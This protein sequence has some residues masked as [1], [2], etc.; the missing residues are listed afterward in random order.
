MIRGKE[1]VLQLHKFNNSQYWRIRRN[2]KDQPIITSDSHDSTFTESHE[3]LE[4]CLRLLGPGTY[5]IQMYNTP[6][7]R[8]NWKHANFE[9][10]SGNNSSSNNMPVIS[11]IDSEAEAERRFQLKMKEFELENLKT[12]V[13]ELKKEQSGADRFFA[14]LEPHIGNIINV[15]MQNNGAVAP[16]QV[17]GVE[18]EKLKKAK[19]IQKRINLALNKWSNNEPEMVVLLEKIANLSEN[20]KQTYSMART[21]LMNK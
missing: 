8:K 19:I 9:I 18:D 7:D 2:E 16:A 5:F 10:L 14:A 13:A 15:F 20:D 4:E 12:E 6:S 17:A 21:V 11:G 3:F 1:D